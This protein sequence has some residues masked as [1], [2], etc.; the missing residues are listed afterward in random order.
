[1]KRKPSSILGVL[2][3]ILFFLFTPSFIDCQELIED[4]FLS[5]GETYADPDREDFSFDKQ[6]D[7]AVELSPLSI[8]SLRENNL[9]DSLTGL[10]LQIPASDQK[11]FTLCC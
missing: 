10:A 11:P 2:V 3:I 9:F 4:N 6:L 8:F 5:S 7:S 1:V